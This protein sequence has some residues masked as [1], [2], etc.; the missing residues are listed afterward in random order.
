MFLYNKINLKIELIFKNKME[1][2]TI[3]W[4]DSNVYNT[5]NTLF[6]YAYMRNEN[7]IRF[8]DFNE[9]FKYIIENKNN[10]III[11]SNTNGKI[12]VDKINDLNNILEINIFCRDK[13]KPLVW[14]HDY[15]KIVKVIDKGFEF[16]ELIKEINKKYKLNYISY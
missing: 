8:S 15:S 4:H 16:G 7:V 11:T 1:D 2:T 14:L 5:E 3:I 9:C 13:R 10:Y 6:Y 12:L